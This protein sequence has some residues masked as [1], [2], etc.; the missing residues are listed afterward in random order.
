MQ[1]DLI[2]IAKRDI[3]ANTLG[4]LAVTGVFDMPKL[5]DSGI[6]IA[7]GTKVYWAAGPQVVMPDSGAGVYLGK[8]L[9]AA[10]DVDASVRVRLDQ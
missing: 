6:T 1:G 3:P 9:R 2:G 8:A 10:G 7:A 5:A 4:A